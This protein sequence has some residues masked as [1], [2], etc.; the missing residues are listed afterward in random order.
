VKKPRFFC[1]NCGAEVNRNEKICPQCGRFFASIRCPRCG[2]TGAE[3]LFVS[4]CP[5]CGFSV[6]GAPPEN[7]RKAPVK[8]ERQKSVD[9]LPLWV[10]ILTALAAIGVLGMV[11]ALL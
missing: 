1:D 9:T 2:F 8:K 11:V 7:S 5:V 4:G 10:Y 6:P 3:K